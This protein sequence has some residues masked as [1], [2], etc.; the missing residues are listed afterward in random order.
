[1]LRFPTCLPTS[2]KFT[3]RC[4]RP[5][6]AIRDCFITV[7]SI[8]NISTDVVSAWRYA[9]YTRLINSIQVSRPAPSGTYFKHVASSPSIQIQTLDGT[10][11]LISVFQEQKLLSSM[12]GYP[13]G[14]TPVLKHTSPDSSWPLMSLWI[15]V[16]WYQYVTNKQH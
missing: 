10:Q 11:Q 5:G 14:L 3:T 6:Y 2:G 12:Q 4:I 16:T 8:T 9:K 1:M 13:F 15:Y 7:P